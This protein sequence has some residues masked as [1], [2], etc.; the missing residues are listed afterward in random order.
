VIAIAIVISMMIAGLAGALIPITLVR[1]GFD[2]AQASSIFLTTVTDVMGFF[3]FLG[4]ATVF[5][6]WL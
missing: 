5:Y 1:L 4:V 3:S 6:V 2:P